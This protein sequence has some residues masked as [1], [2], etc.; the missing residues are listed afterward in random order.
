MESS[1]ICHKEAKVL[2]APALKAT[3]ANPNAARLSPAAVSQA[4]NTSSS[5]GSVRFCALLLS[6]LSSSA[7]LRRLSAANIN[8][9][10]GFE[11]NCP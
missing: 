1:P 4:L 10:F 11:L 3:P 6:K 5:I 7:T 9:S 8:V 2:L